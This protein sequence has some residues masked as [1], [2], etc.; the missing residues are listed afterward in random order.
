MCLPVKKVPFSSVLFLVTHVY[1]VI[2]EWSPR[3]LRALR[4]LPCPY[5]GF[6]V[7]TRPSLSITVFT[8]TSLFITVLALSFPYPSF[9]HPLLSM[10]VL[11]PVH[12]RPSKSFSVHICPSLSISVLSHP[13][14]STPVLLRPYES[15]SIYQY[16]P[17]TYRPFPSMSI[18]VYS[19]H[20][21]SIFLPVFQCPHVLSCP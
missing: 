19:R 15:F 11:F 7:H 8:S 14:L 10:P 20:S 12:T 4:P 16:F 13:S 3:G 17:Y 6:P 18:A 1:T 2:S 21:L 5:P 9:P